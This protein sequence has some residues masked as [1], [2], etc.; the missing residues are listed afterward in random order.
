[1]RNTDS[2]GM[3]NIQIYY[4]LLNRSDPQC[5]PPLK[6]TLVWRNKNELIKKQNKEKYLQILQNTFDI[7]RPVALLGCY[8]RGIA[9]KSKAQLSQAS[10]HAVAVDW[11]LY[12][13][14]C[15]TSL[16]AT[17]SYTQSIVSYHR[18]WVHAQG[19]YEPFKI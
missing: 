16:K 18:A 5:K 4:T 17:Q 13:Q 12:R 1:M 8:Q 19:H 11:T 3:K 7:Y 6:Y 15:R 14:Q 10:L 9:L 2:T